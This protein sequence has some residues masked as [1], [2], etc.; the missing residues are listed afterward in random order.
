M[1]AKSSSYT[2]DGAKSTTRTACFSIDK[3][4]LV[5]TSLLMGDDTKNDNDI[6]KKIISQAMS[7]G[8]IF[9]TG[10]KYGR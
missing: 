4:V 6:N 5:T 2:T 8:K 7:M 9:M 1:Y 3:P 10:Q